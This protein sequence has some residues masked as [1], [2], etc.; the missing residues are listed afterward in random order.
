MISSINATHVINQLA[1]AF[2]FIGILLDIA[3]IQDSGTA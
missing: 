1:K 2:S 3:I